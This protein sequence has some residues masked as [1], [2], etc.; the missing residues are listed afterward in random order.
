MKIRFFNVVLCSLVLS[1]ANCS[2][3]PDY[4]H[5]N[6]WAPA[7][8][9][10]TDQQ[11][12]YALHHVVAGRLDPQWW[13]CFNDPLLTQL[14]ERAVSANLDVQMATQRLVAGRAQL[15]IAGAARFPTLGGSAAFQKTQYSQK[16]FQRGLEEI[17]NREPILGNVVNPS[18][19]DIPSFNE[20]DAALDTSWELDLWG[21]VRRQYESAHA[22]LQ[23]S[24]EDRRGILIAQLAEIAR[25]YITLRGLQ[26]QLSIVKQ[27]ETV[28]L[29]ILQL[30]KERF[31]GGLVTE[32]DVHDAESQLEQ[33][34]AEAPRLEQQVVEYINALGLLLGEPPRALNSEL[35]IETPIPP[36][37]PVVP[38]G[39]P[40]ELAQ[41]R[42]DI[43]EAEAKLHSA[44]ADIGIAMAD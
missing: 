31:R 34:K 14:E 44:T 19:I 16:F 18:D 21:R 28:A 12:E 8:W 22:L 35:A 5:Q 13:R 30:A 38:I 10:K 17:K 29:Q 26:A 25:N 33:T 9:P 43:R 3:G 36:T 11:S 41:R 20:W 2:V 7:T 32:L 24:E 1:V 39:F 6:G 15:L 37:P 40:S 23:A 42:P 27:N 4:H